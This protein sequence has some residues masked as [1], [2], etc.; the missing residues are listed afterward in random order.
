MKYFVVII[1]ACLLIGCKNEEEERVLGIGIDPEL[2]I[3]QYT[4]SK[5]GGSIEIYSQIGSPIHFY[6]SPS[7]D[8]TGDAPIRT[9]YALEGEW[10]KVFYGKSDKYEWTDGIV[11]EVDPNETGQERI[12]P[13]TLMSGDFGCHT[14]YKQ[15][16]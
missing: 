13:I 8:K 2:N 15:E 11:I 12:V 14:L 3:S 7:K 1:L 4:F 16:K 10:Y 9:D 5:E 6:Y